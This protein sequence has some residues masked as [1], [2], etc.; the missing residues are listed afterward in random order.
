M[1][2]IH[3]EFRQLSVS[4]RVLAL[5][6][7]LEKY[8]VPYDAFIIEACRNPYSWPL[9]T[10]EDYAQTWLERN[11]AIERSLAD[12]IFSMIVW[13]KAEAKLSFSDWTLEAIYSEA[14]IFDK[15]RAYPLAGSLKIDTSSGFRI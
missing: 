4:E 7:L 15:M 10:Q 14:V 6:F 2:T 8:E 1:T 13:S 3:K 11:I 9:K 5:K 12:T